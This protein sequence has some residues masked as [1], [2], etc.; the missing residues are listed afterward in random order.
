[1][2]QLYYRY[3]TMNAGKSIELIKVA[4]NYE[5]RGKRVLVFVPGVDD[6]FG[7]GVVASRIGAIPE[8]VIDG[9]TGFLFPPGDAGELASSVARLIKDRDLCRRMGRA[10]RRTLMEKASTEAI[11]GQHL[12]LYS[13]VMSDN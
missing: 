11:I 9:S 8:M 12:K 6:R 2:A 3:S 7:E 4:Y 13:R 10:G 1:M 5:E